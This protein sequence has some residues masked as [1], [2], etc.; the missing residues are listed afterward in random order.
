MA[1][2]LLSTLTS[3][4]TP[5]LLFLAFNIELGLAQAVL[6]NIVV[7]FGLDAAQHTR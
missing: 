2:S 4:L 7:L 3:A 6:I 5:Y 1:L